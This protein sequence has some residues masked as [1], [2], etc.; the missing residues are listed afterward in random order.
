MKV[1]KKEKGLIDG[2]G[3]KKE[4]R[5]ASRCLKVRFFL[6]AL[7]VW[8]FGKGQ[9]CFSNRREREREREREYQ[10]CDCVCETIPLLKIL[11]CR[12]ST[13]SLYSIINQ[14]EI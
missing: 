13:N 12:Q 14:H 5:L 8:P 4:R 7:W 2:I 11:Q 3:W 6:G 9:F 10:M 1:G